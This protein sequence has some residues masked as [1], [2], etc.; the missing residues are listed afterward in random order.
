MAPYATN[1]RPPRTMTEA[2]QAALLKTTGEHARGF[3]DHILFALALGTGLRES[4]VL[5]LNVGDV[6]D[7]RGK[8]KRRITLRV[9]KRCTDSPMPQDVFLP[10]ALMFK[11][12]KFLKWKT[13]HHESLDND[14]P[15]FISRRKKRLS[16]RMVREAF[17]QWQKKAGLS[18]RYSF[19]S[20]R[21]AACSNIYRREHDI[22][23]V[24]RFARHVNI[25]TTTIYA[26]PSDE[27]LVRAVKDLPC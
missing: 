12:G 17:H 23:L 1:R 4:E 3:R 19:H 10:D 21:H 11:L 26:Q 16:A 22:R 8:V 25:T 5:G 2:E 18:R 20:I 7:D 27:D 9:Y 6:M 15:L 24:Q 14:A 13:S